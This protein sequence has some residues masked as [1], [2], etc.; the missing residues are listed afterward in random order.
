MAER[1]D[2]STLPGK[3]ELQDML[4]EGISFKAIG[5]QIGGSNVLVK[6]LLKEY[7]LYQKKERVKR[8]YGSLPDGE[9]VMENLETMKVSEIAKLYNVTEKAVRQKIEYYLKKHQP[10]FEAEWGK[11]NQ[12]YSEYLRQEQRENERLRKIPVKRIIKA[13]DIPRGFIW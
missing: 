9:T 7:G 4:D 11:V 8:S 3:E 1:I 5:E 12:W 6:T 10:Q 2:R 13:E